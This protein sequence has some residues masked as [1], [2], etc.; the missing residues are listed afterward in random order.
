MNVILEGNG[1]LEKTHTSSGRIPLLKGYRF[2]VNTLLEC[3][4]TMK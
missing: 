2:Y 4:S 3:V 1:Y